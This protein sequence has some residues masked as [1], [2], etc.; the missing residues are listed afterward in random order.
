MDRNTADEDNDQS[1]A[2]IL[3]DY[4]LRPFV[5]GVSF[6]LAHYITFIFIAPR[7]FK[8]LTG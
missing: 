2:D 3:Y 4:V 7:I 1:T 6:G 8:K 5:R